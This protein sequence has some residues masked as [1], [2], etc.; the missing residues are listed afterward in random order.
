MDRLAARRPVINRMKELFI[1]PPARNT[2]S[3]ELKPA[4]QCRATLGSELANS[5]VATLLVAAQVT[6]LPFTFMSTIGWAGPCR[7]R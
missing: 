1:F 6:G 7:A 3:V 2:C 4:S 5:S